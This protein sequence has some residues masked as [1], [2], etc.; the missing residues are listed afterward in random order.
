MVIGFMDKFSRS[1]EITKLTFSIIK[2]DKTMLLFPLLSSIFS[3]LF[4][5]ALIVPAIFLPFLTNGV[6]N[7]VTVFAILF[8]LY[9]GLAFL[10]TFFNVCVVYY[11]KETFANKEVTFSNTLGFAFSNI[12]LIAAWALVSATVS[13]LIRVLE[14]ATRRMGGIG[15]IISRMILAGAAMGWAIA[16]VF[17]IPSIVYDKK[18]PFA[19]IKQSVG[20]LRKTWGESLIR[21]VGLGMIQGLIT[22]LGGALLLFLAF[23]SFT[24][25]I[26]L[27]IIMLVVFVLFLVVV[28]LVFQIANDVFNT[29][30]F[31]FAQTGKVPSGYDQK[32]LQDAFAQ[33]TSNQNRL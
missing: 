13:V 23:I 10:A 31:E 2:K 30:L 33:D 26:T 7:E 4:V 32:S 6:V 5:L 21:Y 17:V 20:V 19:A 12:G 14:N 25:S 8:V 11:T 29:A 9:F 15:Q 27:G 22:I 18:T 24:I 28:S 16:T 3:I 1:W